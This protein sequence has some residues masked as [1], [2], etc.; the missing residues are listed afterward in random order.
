MAFPF[1][2]GSLVGSFFFTAEHISFFN[3]VN[4]LQRMTCIFAYNKTK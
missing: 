4:F 3:V 2:V 1:G